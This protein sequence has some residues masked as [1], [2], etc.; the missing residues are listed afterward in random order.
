M[1]HLSEI[2]IL[3]EKDVKITNQRA[4]LG[5]KTYAISEIASVSI[6]VN[7]PKLFLPIFFIVIAGVLSVL[8]AVSDMREYSECLN[9]GM[10]IGIAGS[11]LF[12]LSRK[13]K[14]NVRIKNASGEMKV[15]EAFDKDHVE[16][17]VKALNEAIARKE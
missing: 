8:I 17:V 9:T 11:V 12:I 14:Y 3:K 16:R 6:D 7:E 13:T 15:L 4:I 10:Y 1:T 2:N 5:T